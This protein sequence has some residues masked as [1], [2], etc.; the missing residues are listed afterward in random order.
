LRLPAAEQSTRDIGPP[1][2]QFRGEERV[3]SKTSFVLGRDP[4][5]D[6]V[7]ESELYPHVS[8]RHCEIVFDR[9]HYLL[10]DRSR[11]GTMLNDRP[12]DKQAPLHSGDRIQLGP[13]GPVLRFLGEPSRG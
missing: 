4:A 8:A 6:M 3:L 10:Y 1:R 12:V 7:F 5:C 2:L 13:R 9:R 11:H